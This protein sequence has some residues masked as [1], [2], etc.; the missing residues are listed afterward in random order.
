MSFDL[1]SRFPDR[2]F[3]FIPPDRSRRFQAA[4]F[5]FL[6]AP[7]L[8]VAMFTFV[9]PISLIKLIAVSAASAQFGSP[10]YEINLLPT[11]EQMAPPEDATGM[12]ANQ[13]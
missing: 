13:E 7:V 9:L 3:A 2:S 8:F 11:R 4:P 5:F 10:G 12:T 1:W 6:M